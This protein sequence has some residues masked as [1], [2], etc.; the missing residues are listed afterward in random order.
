MPLSSSSS[1]LSFSSYLQCAALLSPVTTIH[2]F[3]RHK[4]EIGICMESEVYS[5]LPNKSSLLMLV[6]MPSPLLLSKPRIPFVTFQLASLTHSSFVQYY[7]S[8]LLPS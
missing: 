8:L 6:S 7:T 4:L 2:M 1:L 3:H 5:L